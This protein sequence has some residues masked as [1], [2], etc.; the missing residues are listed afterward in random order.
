[1]VLPL[2]NI[3]RVGRKCSS[4]YLSFLGSHRS[5]VASSFCLFLLPICCWRRPF[6]SFIIFSR[7]SFLNSPIS[8]RFSVGGC[9]F[10]SRRTWFCNDDNQFVLRTNAKHGPYLQ[11]LTLIRPVRMISPN[12]FV[13]GNTTGKSQA[14]KKGIL[15]FGERQSVSCLPRSFSVKKKKNTCN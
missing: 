7:I 14:C 13:N 5:C 12:S 6:D 8:S 10:C 9:G 11:E 1:M 4:M 15:S 3:P 2:P